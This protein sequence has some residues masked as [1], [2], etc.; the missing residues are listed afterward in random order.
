M[1][2]NAPID[3]LRESFDVMFYGI[4]NKPERNGQ[5]GAT[6]F[7]IMNEGKMVII[8]NVE[9]KVA[10]TLNILCSFLS[11]SR[12]VACSIFTWM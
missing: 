1:H 4:V 3:T 10:R 5:K 11:I 12:S 9:A 8:N 7:Y 6:P 2:S